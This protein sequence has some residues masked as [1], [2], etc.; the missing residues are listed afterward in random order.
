MVGAHSF[1]EGSILGWESKIGAW[2]R[3]EN[4]TILGEDVAT[5][6]ELQLNGAIVL[7]HKELKE[8]VAQ[9]KIIL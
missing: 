3:V 7:P 5:K 6:P 8:S 4:L 1:V 2:N 9:P